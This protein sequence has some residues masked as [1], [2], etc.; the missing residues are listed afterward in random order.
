[1]QL[2][3]NQEAEKKVKTYCYYLASLSQTES[4]NSC[5]DNCNNMGAGMVQ[6]RWEEIGKSEDDEAG[7]SVKC[8]CSSSDWNY[9]R[10]KK[11]PS[12]GTWW[13]AWTGHLCFIS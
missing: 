4:L 1:M 3:T 6:I 8:G 11:H 2:C 5:T 7:T 10:G 9:S 13:D 12:E